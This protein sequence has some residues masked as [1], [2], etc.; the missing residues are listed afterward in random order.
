MKDSFEYQY[1][2]LSLKSSL[3]SGFGSISKIFDQQQIGSKYFS[4]LDISDVFK[5]SI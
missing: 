5:G 4:N 3:F 2:L 1:L